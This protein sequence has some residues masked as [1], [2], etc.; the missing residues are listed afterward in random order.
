MKEEIFDAFPQY[1]DTEKEADQPPS[2]HRRYN[3][4]L[5]QR[6]YLF[7]ANVFSQELIEKLEERPNFTCKTN[8]EVSNFNMDKNG[9]VKSVSILGKTGQQVECDAVVVCSGAYTSNIL[10]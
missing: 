3:L 4:A 6:A 7:D 9:I 10:N 5:R 2:M 8:S 1:V